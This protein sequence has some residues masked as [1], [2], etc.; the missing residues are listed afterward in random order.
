MHEAI[1]N[2]DGMSPETLVQ[3]TAH[4]GLRLFQDRFFLLFPFFPPFFFCSVC[5]SRGIFSLFGAGSALQ[6]RGLTRA[7]RGRLVTDDERK[8]ADDTMNRIVKASF[9]SMEVDKVA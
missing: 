7:L 6:T 3:L 4:E 5:A 8:W 2:K 9:P 1:R